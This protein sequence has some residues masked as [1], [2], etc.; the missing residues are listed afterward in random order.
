MIKRLNNAKRQTN[1]LV[2]NIE[3]VRHLRALFIFFLS[4]THF[5]L[6]KLADIKIYTYICR[7]IV[8]NANATE[9]IRTEVLLL[10]G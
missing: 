10:F 8:I 6:K 3:G 4:N 7:K 5:F 2:C 9:N 1:Y